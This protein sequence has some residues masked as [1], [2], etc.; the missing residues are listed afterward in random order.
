ME[1]EVTEPQHYDTTIKLQ[2]LA[3]HIIASRSAFKPKKSLIARDFGEIL[4]FT[5]RDL[6]TYWCLM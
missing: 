4:C 1:K 2:T 5:V 6:T 3:Q